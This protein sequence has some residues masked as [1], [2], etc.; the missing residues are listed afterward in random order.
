MHSAVVTPIPSNVVKLGEG[1]LLTTVANPGIAAPDA[2]RRPPACH[3][4]TFLSRRTGAPGRPSPGRRDTSRIGVEASTQ[5]R[6]RPVDPRQLAL[7]PAAAQRP[8]DERGDLGH[9]R[10]SEAGG[11]LGCRAEP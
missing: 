6:D 7:V 10:L 8:G 4:R 2:P 9:L 5:V 11:G 3:G 1:F